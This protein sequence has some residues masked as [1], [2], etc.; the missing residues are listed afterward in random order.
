MCFYRGR[1][2]EFKDIFSQEDS[3]VFCKDVCSVMEVLGHEYISDQWRLFIDSSKVSLKVVLHHNGNRFPSVPLALAAN[4]KESHESMKLLLG[5]IKYDEFNWKL[6]GELKVVALLLG[7]QL[8]YTKYCCF[9]CEWESRDKKNHYVNKLWHKRASLTSGGKNFVNPPL[10]LPEKIYLPHLYIKLGV[11]KNF[12]KGMDKTSRGFEYVRSKFPNV[13]DAKIKEDIHVFIGPQISELMQDKQFDED[14]N[15]T[16]RNAWLSSKRICKNFLGNHKAAN[17]Q[18]VVQDLLTS[19]KAIGYNI[20]LKIY[21][22][23][24]HLDFFP[25]NL[26]EVSD[27]HSERFHQDIMGMEK[28]Y[29]GKWT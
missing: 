9:L 1:H 21:F 10:V 13:S 20:I 17:Y 27:E 19:C 25:D 23:E 2:Q 6:R 15:E 24:S 22:L 7:K 5:K 3:V 14:L 29:Q 11:M 4:M 12:V 26:S 16:E 28:R 18:D 8:G